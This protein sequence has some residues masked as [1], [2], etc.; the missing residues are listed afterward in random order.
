[1]MQFLPL[2]ASWASGADLVG[3][4]TISTADTAVFLTEIDPSLWMSTVNVAVDPAEALISR[5]IIDQGYGNAAQDSLVEFGFNEGVLNIPGSDLVLFE[6][7][8]MTDV[9]DYAVSLDWDGHALEIDVPG[10]SFTNSGFVA[11][12]YISYTGPFETPVYGREIDFTDWGVAEGGL[13]FSLRMRTV[14]PHCD[15]LG[16][17][18]LCE[19]GDHDG[20][21]NDED[22]CPGF[23]DRL[24]ADADGIPD[25]CDDCPVDDLPDADADGV[26]NGA[27]QCPGFDDRIDPDGDGVPSACDDCPNA[28]EPSDDD[29]DDVCDNLDVCAGHDDNEDG[30]DDGLADGCDPCPNLAEPSDLDGD[31]VCDDVDDCIDPIDSDGDGVPDSCDSCPNDPP[32]SDD[33]EDGVCDSVDVCPEGDDAVD[34]DAD[35]K[36]DACDLCPVDAL[37][38]SD[39]DGSC[40]L[41]DL[42]PGFDDTADVDGDSI[43]DACDACAEGAIDVD[44]DG[45]CLPWDCD[46]A[47]PSRFPGNEELCNGIDDDCSGLLGADEVDEDADGVLSCDGDCDDSDPTRYPGALDECDGVDQNCD[48][49]AEEDGD[50]DGVAACADCDDADPSRAPL[51]PDMC[52]DDVDQDCDGRDAVCPDL[53]V[54]FQP[55]AEEGCGCG[56]CDQGGGIVPMGWGLALFFVRRRRLAR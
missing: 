39:L 35:G 16:I 48:G 43:P 53:P 6:A 22:V 30:D 33:D 11:N 36:A 31:D 14:D 46:D 50:G 56:G 21:C 24:D 7:F 15:P 1:M 12:L 3:P 44:G 29:G 41:D 52:G 20:M 25:D 55:I 26:C 13:V 37:D 38:D 2:V 18:W 17:G 34:T 49:V 42:C 32:P 40:D 45:S 54:E 23:D 28:A 47:D 4:W 8:Y 9:G 27:D 10:D 19:D 5:P 51:F